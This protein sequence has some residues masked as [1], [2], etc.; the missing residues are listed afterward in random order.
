LLLS[1][2]AIIGQRDVSLISHSISG[3]VVIYNRYLINNPGSVKHAMKLEEI[4]EVY[5]PSSEVV[6][7]PSKEEI[8]LEL[9]EL[10]YEKCCLRYEDLYKAVWNQFNY[11]I[12]ATGAVLA[13]GKDTVAIPLLI[14]IATIPLIFWFWITFEPLNQYGDKVS[15]RAF[16]IETSLN[17]SIGEHPPELLTDFSIASPIDRDKIKAESEV[18][19]YLANPAGMKHFTRFY[20]RADIAREAKDSYHAPRVR[21]AVRLLAVGLHIAFF[22]ALFFTIFRPSLPT[23]ETKIS[24][25][26]TPPNLTVI[27]PADWKS[28]VEGQKQVSEA[29]T[30]Q[31]NAVNKSSIAV[32]QLESRIEKLEGR[33]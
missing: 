14:C 6:S 24:V 10:E 26:G 19:S 33:K 32:G 5:R 8:K 16:E 1:T 30:T 12:I 31:T 22:V 7:M 15:F 2:E 29:I 27:S 17:E 13:L 28:F 3:E 25:K 11:F 20:L 4:P 18:K 21:T 9:L 23:D